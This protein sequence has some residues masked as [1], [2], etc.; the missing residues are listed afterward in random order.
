MSIRLNAFLLSL[1][2]LAACVP[3]NTA[4]SA[5]FD[6]TAREA[7][8]EEEKTDAAELSFS[9]DAV[10]PYVQ[11]LQAR[12]EGDY[13]KAIDFLS[14]TVKA[15]PNNAALVS[16]MLSL[17]ALEGRTAEAMPYAEAELKNDPTSLLA[18]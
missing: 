15:D 7:V 9:A 10:G 4:G 11:Y 8:P 3:E 13:K 2:V 12:Q 1:F 5:A 14:E 18:S 16:E 6:K 17:L